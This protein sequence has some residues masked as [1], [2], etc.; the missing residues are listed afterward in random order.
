MKSPRALA[1]E[2]ITKVLKNNDFTDTLL[3]KMPKGEKSDDTE[4]IYNVVKGTIKMQGNLEFLAKPHVER[5]ASTDLKMRSLIYMA[6]YQLRYMNIPE[7]AAVNETVELTK[8]IYGDAQAGFINAVLRSYLR[9]PEREY[10]TDPVARLAA[11]HSFPEELVDIWVKNW[12]E[13]ATE[14]LCLYYNEPPRLHLRAN[15]LE[16]DAGKLLQYFTKRGVKV[17]AS[18]AS[19]NML[20][21][22]DAKYIFNDVS[23]SEGYLSIQDTSA[24]LV[25]ELLDPQKEEEILDMFA[26]PGG[27]ATY[28]AELMRN[29]GRITALDKSPAKVKLIKQAVDRLKIENLRAQDA[30]ALTWGP[31]TPSYNRVLLDV[32]CSGWGVFQKKA[33]LRWQNNQDM[34]SLYKL[35]E[36]ALERGSLFVKPGGTLVYSTCTLNERENQAQVEKFLSL[37]PEFSL[38]PADTVINSAYTQ[39]PYLLTT[40]YKHLMDGAFAARMQKAKEEGK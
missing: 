17:E 33:D 6:I 39:G 38:I 18:Q 8:S 21:T 9:N 36:Q 1:Y 11:E 2:V 15:I 24:A 3:S 27:K 28:M 37:H 19:A 31:A 10:P 35:Q 13:E 34:K 26:A 7:H 32:P 5:W 25:V 22:S 14:F 16:T 12:G 4:F 29:T 30:D 23:F 40:P 20:V